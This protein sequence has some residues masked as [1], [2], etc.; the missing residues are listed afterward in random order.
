MSAITGIVL[1]LGVL[2]A[3]LGALAFVRLAT[4]LERLHAVTFVNV[5]A[6]AAI[7]LAALLTD[8][9][10]SRSLKCLLLLVV[11]LPV[12][13]LLTHVTGR[14]LHTRSGEWR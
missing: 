6:G 13:A 1:G 3:W 11:T 4:A 9:V 5:A 8:G 12:G 14:A 7:V 2:A 10:S